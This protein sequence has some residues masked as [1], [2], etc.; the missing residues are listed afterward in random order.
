M[1]AIGRR[2][3][4]NEERSDFSAPMLRRASNYVW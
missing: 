2:I 4:V 1:R 3:V